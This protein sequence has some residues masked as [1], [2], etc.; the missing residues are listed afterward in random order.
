M[1]T[2]A[3]GSRAPCTSSAGTCI[4][5]GRNALNWFSSRQ[6]TSTGSAF[7]A[8]RTNVGD[9]RL[10]VGVIR[11]E[12]GRR[13][14]GRSFAG[15]PDARCPAWAATA[16]RDRSRTRAARRPPG[17]RDAAAPPWPRSSRRATVRSRYT[18]RRCAAGMRCC[19]H[20]TTPRTS[21]T[22]RSGVSHAVASRGVA[23]YPRMSSANTSNP[24]SASASM[25][26]RF[27]PG[28]CRSK[29]G[30]LLHVRPCSS[31]IAAR[32]CAPRF[33][34]TARWWPS[35]TTSC[36]TAGAPQAAL[37]HR[38][39]ALTHS[40]P[41]HPAPRHSAP[42]TQHPAPYCPCSRRM[43]ARSAFIVSGERDEELV[44][45]PARVGEHPASRSRRSDR[46]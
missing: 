20:A 23:P 10:R 11:E 38:A 26:D 43:P 35:T 25:N 45:E 14:V 34:Q 40:A 6:S 24:A 36:L 41:T 33:C 29:L 12:V 27:S 4:C 39:R 32:G 3:C 44:R 31:R 9:R 37:T 28:T 22:A 18:G 15:A 19:S 13:G 7:S 46:G 5:A 1:A 2:G 30:R 21:A 16:R 42:S 8:A 17:S